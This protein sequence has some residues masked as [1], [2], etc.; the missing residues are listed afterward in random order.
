[1][2]IALPLLST[3]KGSAN[4][5]ESTPLTQIFEAF[6]NDKS[7]SKNSLSSPSV[8]HQ[9]EPVQDFVEGSNVTLHSVDYTTLQNRTNDTPENGSGHFNLDE[10]LLTMFLPSA[11][12]PTAATADAGSCNDKVDQIN[13]VSQ[14]SKINFS[15]A[16]DKPTSS[17]MGPGTCDNVSVH[18][19]PPSAREHQPSRITTQRMV[20]PKLRLLASRLGPEAVDYVVSTFCRGNAG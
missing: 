19:I 8:D 5:N 18:S 16:R 12:A 6:N 1:M 20:D 13:A 15:H 2:E 7:K 17:E 4:D 3:S 9:N 10:A 11:L 14:D